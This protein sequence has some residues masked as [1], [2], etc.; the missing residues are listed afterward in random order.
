MTLHRFFVARQSIEGGTVT[1]AGEIAHQIADV[2]RMTAGEHILV[3]DNSGWQMETELSYVSGSRVVGQIVR[4]S[5]ARGEPRIKVSL[6]QGM[7]QSRNL[8]FVL[9]KGTELGIV[10]FVPIISSRCVIANLEDVN[11]KLE[12]WERIV[13]EAAE[14]SRRGRLPLIEPATFFQQACERARHAGGLFLMPWEEERTVSLHSML[15]SAPLPFT[16]SLFIGPEGGFS[17]DEVQI[18]RGYG[19]RT[20]SLGPR[21]LR[22]ETAGLVAASAMFYESGDLNPLPE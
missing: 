10:E 21:V 5:L 20:V 9:Q 1:I 17:E 7:L 16:I 14:Q 15:T 22:A 2:L 4:R 13:R 8:E 6:Y 3:L 19:A 12:R 11:K 18:A